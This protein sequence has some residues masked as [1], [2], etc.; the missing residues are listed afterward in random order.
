MKMPTR[1]SKICY[2]HDK[3]LGQIADYIKTHY[4]ERGE[5]IVADRSFECG[6]S[7]E[8]CYAE[9]YNNDG[10]SL[11]MAVGILYQCKVFCPFFN[12]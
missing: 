12:L 1:D 11:A 8:K 3:T 5:E 4:I 9:G 6:D 10:M 7:C 2:C